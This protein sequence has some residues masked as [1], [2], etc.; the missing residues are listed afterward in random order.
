MILSRRGVVG[1]YYKNNLVNE[2]SGN[3]I[4]VGWK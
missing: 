4:N 3:L 2:V 1:F